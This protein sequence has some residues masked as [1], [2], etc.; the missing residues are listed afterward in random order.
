MLLPALVSVGEPRPLAILHSSALLEQSELKI[1]GSVLLV[2][3][4]KIKHTM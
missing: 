2:D 4:L 1:A 3:I